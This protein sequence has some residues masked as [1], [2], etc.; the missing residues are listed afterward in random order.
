M[1]QLIKCR[2]AQN[3]THS[4][5]STAQC[6]AVTNRSTVASAI[7]NSAENPGVIRRNTPPNQQSPGI[8]SQSSS[9]LCS[10]TVTDVPRFA[11]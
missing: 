10:S 2:W 3:S 6:N 11:W 7:Y 8:L 9:L 4:S 1:K 5:W